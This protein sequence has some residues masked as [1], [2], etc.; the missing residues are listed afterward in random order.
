MPLLALLPG[1]GTPEAQKRNI[2]KATLKKYSITIAVISLIAWA[3]AAA[4]HARPGTFVFVLS[5]MGAS[6]SWL[7]AGALCAID[8]RT[9]ARGANGPMYLG[10]FVLTSLSVVVE[11]P[12]QDHLGTG[13]VRP[14][15]IILFFVWL[16]WIALCGRW[17]GTAGKR[18][19]VIR[20]RSWPTRTELPALPRETRGVR[21]HSGAITQSS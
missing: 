19:N 8:G 6:L 20:I 7:G 10:F 12:L 1:L 4:V 14:F 15:Q 18:C 2:L 3:I 16:T 21:F 17:L 5:A 13:T 11:F 9:M